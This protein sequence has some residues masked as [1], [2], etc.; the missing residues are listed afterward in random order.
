MISTYFI[1]LVVIAVLSFFLAL[2]LLKSLI[3]AVT[4]TLLLVLFLIVVFTGILVYDL[5]T[6]RTSLNDSAHFVIVEDGDEITSISLSTNKNDESF[7][8]EEGFDLENESSNNL[9]IIIELDYLIS[10]NSVEILDFGI[11]LTESDLR[12]IYVSDNI[13]EIHTVL[14]SAGRLSN[15]NSGALLNSLVLEFSNHDSFKKAITV[16]LVYKKFRNDY[17]KL[18][19]DIRDDKIQVEPEF[20]SIKTIKSMPD[21]MAKVFIKD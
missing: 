5:N 18:V 4:S 8:I 3:K 10:N 15:E 11:N 2:R 13:G 20:L 19:R 1:I 14:E 6:F 21:F 9:N 16:N 7:T 12:R 17:G